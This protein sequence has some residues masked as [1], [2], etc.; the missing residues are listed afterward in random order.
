[1]IPILALNTTQARPRIDLDRTPRWE[2]YY[3]LFRV[4]Y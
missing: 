4:I 3:Y 1:M 2:G